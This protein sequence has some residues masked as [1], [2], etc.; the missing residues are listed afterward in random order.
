MATTYRLVSLSCPYG[1]SDE[2]WQE[3]YQ[4]H[5]LADVATGIG[6]NGTGYLYRLISVPNGLPPS[7]EKTFLAMY[8]TMESHPLKSERYKGVRKTSHILGEQFLPKDLAHLSVRNYELVETFDPK[9]LGQQVEPAAFLFLQE[10]DPINMTEL[11]RYYRE[12][13]VPRVASDSGFRRT[14][15]HRFLSLDK[16]ND[17][18]ASALSTYEF[19]TIEGPG[20]AAVQD[21]IRHGSQGSQNPQP[22]TKTWTFQLVHHV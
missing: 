16:G 6:H 9:S 5:H 17:S 19:D 12:E 10:L 3:F 8:D 2:K 21:Y 22:A 1:V 13:L 14:L 7:D 18:P 15:L 4:S 20:F 11:R